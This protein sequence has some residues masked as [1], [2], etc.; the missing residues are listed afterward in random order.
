[1]ALELE[2]ELELELTRFHRHIS[3]PS[4]KLL[5]YERA[6]QVYMTNPKSKIYTF[7]N[8]YLRRI[9]NLIPATRQGPLLVLSDRPRIPAFD[10]KAGV[11]ARKVSA[12]QSTFI[13]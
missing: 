7:C 4:K 9:G 6:Q 1:M 2:L 13:I 5:E 3:A 12:R 10:D 8:R 11:A